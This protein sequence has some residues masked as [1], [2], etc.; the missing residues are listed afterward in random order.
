M[1]ICKL[2]M[3]IIMCLCTALVDLAAATDYISG[4]LSHGSESKEETRTQIL[5]VPLSET[6]RVR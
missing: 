2:S 3:Y 6:T 5:E 4:V 1:Y